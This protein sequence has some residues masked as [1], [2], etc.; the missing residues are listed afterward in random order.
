MNVRSAIVGIA[1]AA[2]VA[3]V[4]AEVLTFRFTGRVTQSLPMAPEGSEVTGT[5]SYDTA[6]EPYL[7]S[8]EPNG[9]G[10]GDASYFAPSTIELKVNGHTVTSGITT[11]FIVNNSGGNVEDLIAINGELMVLDGTLFPE[12]NTGLVLGSAPGKTNVLR[13]TRPPRHFP[14]VHRFGGENYGYVLVG[15]GPNDTVLFFRID[16]IVP[17]HG[18]D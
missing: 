8:G 18:D 12:G 17:V 4:H 13:S 16:R 9:P 3:T 1:L 14:N 6:A 2:L 5:F 10:P 15:G 7:Q 11:V